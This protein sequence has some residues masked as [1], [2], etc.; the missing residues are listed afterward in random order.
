MRRMVRSGSSVSLPGTCDPVRPL[1]ATSLCVA[2]QKL[3]YDANAAES[4]ALAL[5][6]TLPKR[7]TYFGGAL[8][9]HP[10]PRDIHHTAKELKESNDAQSGHHS[11]AAVR[12]CGVGGSADRQYRHD[13]RNRHWEHKCGIQHIRLS[14]W[15]TLRTNFCT[16]NRCS[17]HNQH[18]REYTRKHR[19]SASGHCSRNEHQ[20]RR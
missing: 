8:K 19:S 16:G 9:G 15:N 14:A 10:W 4:R 2:V 12:M 20:N 3:M 1:R 18:G 7:S 6:C 11:G 5:R 13:N 17:G